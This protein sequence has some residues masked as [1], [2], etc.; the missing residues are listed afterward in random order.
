M[1]KTALKILA[2]AGAVVF[3]L[4]VCIVG[5]PSLAEDSGLTVQCEDA[6]YKALKSDGTPWAPKA[7]VSTLT[8]ENGQG[9]KGLIFTGDNVGASVEFTFNSDIEGEFDF[10]F[11]ARPNENYF[12]YLD[13]TY[14]GDKIGEGISLKKHDVVLGKTNIDNKVRDFNLGTVT[15]KKGENKV[16][17]KSV[18]GAS[19]PTSVTIVLDDIRFV[20]AQ[21]PTDK[22]E[23]EDLAFTAIDIQGNKVTQSNQY[24]TWAW[25][26]DLGG[27][28]NV[29]GALTYFRSGGL[30]ATVEF[31]LPVREAGEHSIILAYRPNLESYSDIEVYVN[32]KLMGE[33]FTQK[34][35]IK[36]GDEVNVANVARELVMGNAQLVKGDNT[37][38]IKLVK[39]KDNGDMSKTAFT[40]DYIRLGDV[41][42]ESKL[43]FNEPLPEYP[44]VADKTNSKPVT[45]DV[46]D[47]MLDTY[48]GKSETPKTTDKITVY[49]LPECYESS[50]KYKVTADGV[51]IPVYTVSAGSKY[52]DN[53]YSYAAF[54]YD[55][56]KGSVEVK[57]EW[58]ETIKEVTV[59]PQHINPVYTKNGKT[60]TLTIDKNQNYS[61]CIN[62]RY[63][64][65]SA[66]PMQ[67]D[68]PAKTGN[69]IFNITEA[70]YSVSKDM[71]DAQVTA[72]I[73][74]ALDDASAYG[75]TKGNK[76][77]VVYIPAGVYYVGN[78]VISSNTYLYLEGGAV[79]RISDDESL[80]DVKAIKT[81]MTDPLGNSGVSF[82]WWISTA[83]EEVITTDPETEKTKVEVF[84]S[85]D[86]RIGGRG[87]IDGRDAH[88]W[89]TSEEGNHKVGANTV[90]PIATS[91]F[92][93]EGLTVRDAT[94]WSI[95]AVRSDNL[96]FDN[97]KMF[98][99]TKRHHDENDG[100]DICECQNVTVKNSI[101]FAMDDPFSA[102]TWPYRVGITTNWP[103]YPEISSDVT[104]EGCMS[105]TQRMGFKI[106][107][108]TDQ[109]HYNVTFRNCTVIDATTGIGIHASSGA[110]IVYDPV[111]D[112]I[113][114]EK[115]HKGGFYPNSG[116]LYLNVQA[117]GRGNGNLRNV[118]IKNIHVYKGAEGS[119]KIQ[120]SGI[121]SSNAIKGLYF[122]DI[123]FDGVRA[124]TL[125]D[126]KPGL[127]RNEFVY[128]V[129][130]V[131][132]PVDPGDNAPGNENPGNDNPGNENNR[133]ENAGN[134]NNENENAGNQTEK[135]GNT[136]AI[137]VII[138]VCVL[139]V[140][141]AVTV[142]T[143]LKKKKS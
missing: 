10:I 48:E 67:K 100:I 50:A 68:V 21:E 26:L 98:N 23:A 73:Q 36:V 143:V 108:G 58:N 104:F 81:S 76:N 11:S 85:Y 101:G 141:A 27:A 110:G 78:L 115:L 112:G 6:D 16:L 53:D 17:F 20:T 52:A 22:F 89:N 74:K 118:V 133:N 37:V 87:T 127:N 109:C 5:I 91:Y 125:N 90:V 117:N 30:G 130:M 134:E 8:K 38:T 4:S 111:F 137:I 12:A 3:L 93:L 114:I 86:I 69:G 70:P 106:G 95:V 128:N 107:Q 80:L 124:E 129:S 140:A 135:P 44:A 54:D 9:T 61:I 132:T 2:L 131:N 41:V 45:V 14:N 7:S 139:A 15:L 18:E 123:Y 35:G 29:S 55:P 62:G 102:K 122:T 72:A 34:G 1:K 56:S 84:G 126:I 83:F 32:G 71:T 97:I 66:D 138:S 59:S 47:G 99:V 28:A 40:L 136:A 103:G 82:T 46:P 64:V 39:E 13:V 96:T 113:Y 120:L 19:S 49:P 88:Y 92:T 116:W 31:I 57:I 63:L 105:Y 33:A 79:L 51:S 60:L 121:S 142:L 25:N 65:V 24:G 77:G 43:T 75:S 42:D 94:C 119:A